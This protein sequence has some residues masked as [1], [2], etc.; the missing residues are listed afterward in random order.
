MRNPGGR[1]WQPFVSPELRAKPSAMRHLLRSRPPLP[2]I[3]MQLQLRVVRQRADRRTAQ[4][5]PGPKDVCS[6][7]L[8]PSLA[9]VVFTSRRRP[10]YSGLGRFCAGRKSG[11][12]HPACPCMPEPHLLHEHADWISGTAPPAFAFMSLRRPKALVS[13]EGKTLGS[14][15]TALRPEIRV[16]VVQ[17]SPAAGT[18]GAGACVGHANGLAD[19]PIGWMPEGLF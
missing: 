17:F 8:H 9:A 6:D 7:Q 18:F 3:S 19:W 10:G 14:K 11:T 15:I 13:S 4:H 5:M 2:A 1:T 16:S 12:A